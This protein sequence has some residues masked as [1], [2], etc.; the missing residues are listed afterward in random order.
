MIYNHGQPKFPNK[1]FLV[2]SN[3]LGSC[4][5]TTG[6][7]D[8]NPYTGIKYNSDF[9]IITVRDMVRVQHKLLKKLGVMK[10]VT[11]NGGSLGGMQDLEGGVI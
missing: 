4:Y 2:S 9:P 8:I 1:Y 6:P 10:L 5:G 11:L 7:S 3:I